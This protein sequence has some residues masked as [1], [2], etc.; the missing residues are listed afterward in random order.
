MGFTTVQAQDD[1]KVKTSTANTTGTTASIMGRLAPQVTTK[2]HVLQENLRSKYE[3]LRG[4]DFN[5]TEKDFDDLQNE[6]NTNF[7][8]T[9]FQFIKKSVFVSISDNVK[10]YVNYICARNKYFTNID[11]KDRKLAAAKTIEF[12][13]KYARENPKVKLDYYKILEKASEENTNILTKLQTYMQDNIQNPMG[14][15]KKLHDL[16]KQNPKALKAMLSYHFNN[17]PPP[18][19]DTEYKVRL[20]SGLL[21]VKKLF[22]TEHADKLT[23]Q[24]TTLIANIAGGDLKAESIQ[25]V[26]AKL[27]SS[28]EIDP[29]KK[30]GLFEKKTTKS[31]IAGIARNAKKKSEGKFV[32]A[33]PQ[34]SELRYFAFKILL[35][36]QL[37]QFRFRSLNP[38][39]EIICL[40]KIKISKKQ[41]LLSQ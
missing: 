32:K 25:T 5:P 24:M 17:L 30:R 20:I 9:N 40:K 1:T 29:D 11:H 27:K 41:R 37:K 13:M 14:L 22:E 35:S 39:R 38:N 15:V 18:V 10:A 2:P 6:L 12:M 3:C 33:L 21:K 8:L 31:I 19:A 7:T 4:N 28:S 34:G 23:H 16:S 36:M 26:E